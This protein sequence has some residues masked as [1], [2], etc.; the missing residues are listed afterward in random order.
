MGFFPKLQK[1]YCK[2]KE[3]SAPF[4]GRRIFKKRDL[5]CCI[6]C[7]NR[8]VKAGKKHSF[9]P[10]LYRRERP[11]ACAAQEEEKED[12]LF[13]PGR[14]KQY[15]PTCKSWED[16]QNDKDPL[17]RK[18]KAKQ[19]KKKWKKKKIFLENG[20]KRDKKKQK[21]REKEQNKKALPFQKRKGSCPESSCC[22]KKEACE[23]KKSCFNKKFQFFLLY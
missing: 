18:K 14:K 6:F 10:L 13:F 16:P 7:R 1:S 9:T 4:F 19:E 15:A 11:G 12:H 5:F 21:K 8:K 23:K 17:F 20:K 3:S 22:K 2:S